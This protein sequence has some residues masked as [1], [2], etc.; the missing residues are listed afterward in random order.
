M[1]DPSPCSME[2]QEK[3][4]SLQLMSIKYTHGQRGAVSASPQVKVAVILHSP[5]C[6]LGW[7]VDQSH[8]THLCWE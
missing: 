6:V 7:P 1:Q 5:P 3:S 2:E 4:Q 8:L